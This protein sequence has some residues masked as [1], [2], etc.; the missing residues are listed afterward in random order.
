MRTR[1]IAF[2]RR[3]VPR[4]SPLSLSFLVT[5]MSGEGVGGRGSGIGLRGLTLLC[6]ELG[7][8]W[9]LG[10]VR[11]IG[12][13]VD[14]KTLDHLEGELVFREHSADSVAKYSVGMTGETAFG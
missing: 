11:M 1:A 12:A 6:A 8:L 9:V 5:A 14:F 3:P 10:L 4:Q 13:G 2:F 7:L